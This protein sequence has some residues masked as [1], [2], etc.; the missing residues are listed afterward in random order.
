[1]AA[2]RIVTL[3]CLGDVDSPRY[4]DLLAKLISA[5]QSVANSLLQTISK[6]LLRGA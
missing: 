2:L 3:K 4:G 6:W 5:I 1:M